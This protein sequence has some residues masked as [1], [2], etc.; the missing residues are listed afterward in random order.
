MSV[1]RYLALTLL[2]PLLSACEPEVKPAK[3]EP[4]KNVAPAEAKAPAQAPAQALSTPPA[5][6]PAAAPTEAG[7]GPEVPEEPQ[8]VAPVPAA[9]TPSKAAPP[10][11]ASRAEE[12]QASAPVAPVQPEHATLDLSLPPELLEQLSAEGVPGEVAAPLLPPLFEE[13]AAGDPFQLSG[14]L[15]T[16]EDDADYWESVDGAELQFKFKR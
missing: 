4:S 3:V 16:N 10:P 5:D 11:A 9:V 7:P 8:A 15:I 1:M 6:A 12:Q 13:D 2:V 14:R